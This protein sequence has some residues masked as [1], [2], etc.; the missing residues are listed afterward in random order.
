[1]ADANIDRFLALDA[2]TADT[3]VRE[4]DKLGLREVIGYSLQF[5]ETHANS[6]GSDVEEKLGA[7]LLS[8]LN[9]FSTQEKTE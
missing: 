4:D 9:S 8:A 6:R 1:M 7:I 2:D 3:S 5:M